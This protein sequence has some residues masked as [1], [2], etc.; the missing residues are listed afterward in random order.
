MKPRQKQKR[1]YNMK[2]LSF[3]AVTAAVI[4]AIVGIFSLV[5]AGDNNADY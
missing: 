3:F 2:L 5:K 4:A 1:K